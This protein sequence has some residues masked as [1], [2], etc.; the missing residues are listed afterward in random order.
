M[1]LTISSLMAC[2]DRP[3]NGSLTDSIQV[4]GTDTLLTDS[5]HYATALFVETLDSVYQ[6]SA[7]SVFDALLRGNQRYLKN[8]P[9]IFAS[10]DIIPDS[11]LRKK[12]F[13]LLTDIDL[14][15]SPEKIFDLRRPMFIQLSSPACLVDPKQIAV[16]EYAVNYS[17]TRVIIVLANSNS[18]IIGAACDNVQT[19]SFDKITSELAKAMKT[20]QEFADRSSTNKEFVNN[21]AQNQAR[22]STSQILQLSPQLKM[23]SDSGKIIIKSLYFDGSKRTL[24][25]LQQNAT[26]NT[27]T[28][29]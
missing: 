8:K 1:L 23:L 9:A 6:R 15:Q 5:S 21:I 2:K 12:P 4:A 17:S 11:L 28:K 22:L 18:R 26:L 27:L 7:K 3:Q 29:N 16:M 19:G 13:L 25:Q 20:E 14:P 24:T 10:S